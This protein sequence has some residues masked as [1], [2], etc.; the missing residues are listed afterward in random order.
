M[1]FEHA[2]GYAVFRCREAEDIGALLPEVQ[3]AVLE[4]VREGTKVYYTHIHTHLEIYSS[5]L[6]VKMFATKIKNLV[7]TN[8]LIAPLR[9]LI[10]NNNLFDIHKKICGSAN[11]EIPIPAPTIMLI[12]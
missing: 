7:T 12:A 9:L 1:L 2:S 11:L 4:E 5:I 8:C 3:E 6:L 10:A